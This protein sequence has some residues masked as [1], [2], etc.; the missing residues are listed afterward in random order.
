ML[1]TCDSGHGEIFS[2]SLLKA[3]RQLLIENVAA[4]KDAFSARFRSNNTEFR[5]TPEGTSGKTRKNLLTILAVG[6]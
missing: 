3:K 1:R 6:S 2:R 5:E 4:R